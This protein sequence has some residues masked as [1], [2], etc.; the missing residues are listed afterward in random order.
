[1]SMHKSPWAYLSPRPTFWQVRQAWLLYRGEYYAVEYMP[2]CLFRAAVREAY[3]SFAMSAIYCQPY[4]FDIVD[5]WYI[6]MR[7]P[8]KLFFLKKGLFVDRYR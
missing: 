5:R 4:P 6:L 3:P 7:Y 1:M 8:L 2:S